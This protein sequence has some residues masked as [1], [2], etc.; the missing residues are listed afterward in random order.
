MMYLLGLIWYK[1]DINAQRMLGLIYL[2]LAK[3]IVYNVCTIKIL[4][5]VGGECKDQLWDMLWSVLLMLQDM[6]KMIKKIVCYSS[7]W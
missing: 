2:L 3:F 7:L 5:S 4:G 1:T 6:L